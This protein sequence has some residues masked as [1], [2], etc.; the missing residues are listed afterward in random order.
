M[1]RSLVVP[2]GSVEHH[3]SM[4][5]VRQGSGELFQEHVHGRGRDMRDHQR[6]VLAGGWPHGRK[7]VCR[8]KALVAR[9]W[10]PLTLDPPAVRDPAFLADPSLVLEPESYALVGMGSRGFFYGRKKPL[11]SKAST[12][13]ASRWG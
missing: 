12:A 9:A 1:Q 2:A 6:E 10:G 4:R 7:D 8:G 3:H 13:L 5:V 11:F